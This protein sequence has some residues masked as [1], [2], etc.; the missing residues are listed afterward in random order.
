M[1]VT[2]VRNLPAEP[3]VLFFTFYETDSVRYT[4]CQSLV[5]NE[6]SHVYRAA[7]PG[8]VSEIEHHIVFR[9]YCGHGLYS[10]SPAELQIPV[11][12]HFFRIEDL[13]CRGFVYGCFF[14][15]RIGWFP[16]TTTWPHVL[17]SQQSRQTAPDPGELLFKVRSKD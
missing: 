11:P 15:F 5:E 10:R 8:I 2:G 17:T 7:V 12:G 16:G 14:H 3:V 1:F 6:A 4:A 13:H 9:H